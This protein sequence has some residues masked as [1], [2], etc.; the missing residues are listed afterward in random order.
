MT[1]PTQPL[2]EPDLTAAALDQ[3]G[4][5]IIVV[6]VAGTITHWNHKA[7]DLFGFTADQ[8]IGRSVEIII[9][10]RLRTDHWHGFDAAMST[11]HLATDGK[12]RRTRG[13][14]V[15]GG[16]V[17]VT[18]TFAVINAPDGTAV[19]AVAVAREYIKES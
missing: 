13:L 19:G 6:D 1:D 9:P 3:A 8:A 11:G 18:M 2:A 15:D 12:P 7:E 5:G 17:Y 10:E 14:T 4:D 16:K